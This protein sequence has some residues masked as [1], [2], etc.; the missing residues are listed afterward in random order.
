MF[1]LVAKLPC[2]IGTL[3]IVYTLVCGKKENNLANNGIVLLVLIYLYSH[4]FN[5]TVKL[6]SRGLIHLLV[7][8]P[9]L[10]KMVKINRRKFFKK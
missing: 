8:L 1:P 2:L 7:I 10:V 4:I 3:L 9:Y 6:N 5:E